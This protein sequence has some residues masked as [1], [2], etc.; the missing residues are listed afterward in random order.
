MKP[1]Q[2]P[3]TY[4]ANCFSP[5]KMFLNR[6]SLKIWQMIL[7]IIFLVFLMLNPVALNAN[8][9]PEFNLT[10]I[11]PDLV[12]KLSKEDVQQVN[13]LRIEDYK[14]IEKNTN[15]INSL[16]QINAA[17]KDFDKVSTG[18]N[19]KEEYLVMKDKNSLIFQ[20]K[21]P[22]SMDFADFNTINEFKEWLLK[23]WN[24]QNNSYRIISLI[25][26]MAILIISSTL[27]LVFGTS[28]FIWLTKK[29]HLS[30][31]KSYK[32]S[33][34]LTLNALLLSTLAA[35]IVGLFY[36]DITLMMTIQA[37]GLALE[38]LFIFIKTKFNDDLVVK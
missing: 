29:N 14:L 25:L 19:F 38:I 11:M 10:T 17:D 8:K 26:L 34:N 33:V 37:F 4:F 30:S 2:F 27:F 18:I 7:V 22:E 28:L 24:I 15:E 16:I 35:T 5:K 1:S 12:S 32:E 6:F 31:I 21:Y 23:E 20:L 3:V 9:F 36:Y 13:Y